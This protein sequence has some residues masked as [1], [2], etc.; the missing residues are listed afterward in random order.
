[1]AP[2]TQTRWEESVIG[3]MRRVQSMRKRMCIFLHFSEKCVDSIHSCTVCRNPRYCTCLPTTTGRAAMSAMTAMSCDACLPCL[4]VRAGRRPTTAFVRAPAPASP[5][6]RAPETY[7][8]CN[9]AEHQA[10]VPDISEVGLD[11]RAP[12]PSAHAPRAEFNLT[13][14]VHSRPQFRSWYGLRRAAIR[15]RGAT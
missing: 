10:C 9:A 11:R 6:R 3:T 8:S 13:L 7:C 5:E 2:A 12:P 1:M 4:A 15:N 14:H